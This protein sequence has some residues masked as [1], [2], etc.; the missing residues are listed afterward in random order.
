MDGIWDK[1]PPATEEKCDCGKIHKCLDN[2]PDDGC[3]HNLEADE[4]VEVEVSHDE[5]KW[6]KCGDSPKEVGDSMKEGMKIDDKKLRWDL[7][8]WDA[9]EQIVEIMTYGAQKYA[10]NNW[11]KV[12]ANRY[13]AALMRH[14]VAEYKGEDFDIESGFL[15]L[16]H[17]ACNILF[18]LWKKMNE[19]E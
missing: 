12:K 16:A 2:I 14:L 19:V 9:V 15:H 8:P 13:Y 18:L 4:K 6:Y 5:D 11:Q 1:I 7:L 10:P 17:A 3:Y